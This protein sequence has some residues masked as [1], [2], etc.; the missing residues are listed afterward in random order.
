MLND[1]RNK[2]RKEKLDFIGDGLG[3]MNGRE[4]AGFIWLEVI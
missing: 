1:G 3:R 2:N 4:A